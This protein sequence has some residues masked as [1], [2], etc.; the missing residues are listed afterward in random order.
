MGEEKQRLEM[1]NIPPRRLPVR[2]HGWQESDYTLLE[3]AP[4][5]MVVVDGQASKRLIAQ[6]TPKEWPEAFGRHV[7]A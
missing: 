3:S 2:R 7:A 6:L 1:L 5:A 4:D